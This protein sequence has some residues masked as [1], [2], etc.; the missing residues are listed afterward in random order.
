MF[1]VELP[2]V[3]NES[4]IKPEHNSHDKELCMLKISLKMQSFQDNINNDLRNLRTRCL[5]FLT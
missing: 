2:Q 4:E 5:K 1:V 3:A